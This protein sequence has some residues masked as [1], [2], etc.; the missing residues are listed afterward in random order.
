MLRVGPLTGD[1]PSSYRLNFCEHIYFLG[2][3]E[4]IDTS[5][6]GRPPWLHRLAIRVS[7]YPMCES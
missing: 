3:S 5:N 6:S 1:D 4:L 2:L 7:T